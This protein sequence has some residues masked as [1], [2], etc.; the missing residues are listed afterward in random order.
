M[1]SQNKISVE[2]SN[3]KVLTKKDIMQLFSYISLLLYF[4]SD[5]RT[6]LVPNNIEIALLLLGV[7]YFFFSS[8]FTAMDSRSVLTIV[9]AN[10]ILRN[11][12]LLLQVGSTTIIGVL[13]I[14]NKEL[15][16]GSYFDI[17]IP[18]IILS[19]VYIIIFT[20]IGI[21]Y[22]TK[23]IAYQEVLKKK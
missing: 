23:C 15:E 9:K 16:R 3:L 11:K 22:V 14:V 18:Y 8:L 7:I 19:L 21:I 13:L 12:M 4:I 10:Y 1:E 6:A 5:F 20:F 17:D 2:K